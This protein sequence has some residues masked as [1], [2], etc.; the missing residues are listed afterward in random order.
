MASASLETA[1]AEE[2]LAIAE[3]GVV[4]Y[5]VEVQIA[6]LSVSALTTT[7]DDRPRHGYGLSSRFDRSWSTAVIARVAATEIRR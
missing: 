7:C 1:A 3:F 6:F 5:R 4:E 2:S